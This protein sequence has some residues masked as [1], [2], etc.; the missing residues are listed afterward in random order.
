MQRP[1]CNVAKIIISLYFR[2]QNLLY[3]LLFLPSKYIINVTLYKN[4]FYVLYI[5]KML[6]VNFW[7]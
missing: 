6:Q 4:Y 2:Y 7:T 3:H 1:L 5:M